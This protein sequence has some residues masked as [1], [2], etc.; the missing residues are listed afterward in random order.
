VKFIF[1]RSIHYVKHDCGH[2]IAPSRGQRRI[3]RGI[4]LDVFSQW[5]TRGAPWP[6]KDARRSDGIHEDAEGL[7]IT[8]QHGCPTYVIQG[9]HME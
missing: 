6:T 5:T 1:G 8:V 3:G 2:I 4:E 9:V 7:V